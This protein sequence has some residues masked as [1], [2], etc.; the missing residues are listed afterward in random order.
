[1][2]DNWKEQL[3]PESSPWEKR[4]KEIIRRDTIVAEFWNL[5]IEE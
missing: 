4:T 5:N 3:N 1:M 2:A